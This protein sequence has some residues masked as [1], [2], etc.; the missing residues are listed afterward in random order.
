MFC[1]Q[2]GAAS[3]GTAAACLQCGVDLT[4]RV[5]PALN[6]E[7]AVAASKDA[8][9]ALKMLLMDPVGSVGTAYEAL[10]GRQATDVGIA[11]CAFFVISCVIAIRMIARVA[12]RLSFGA[13]IFSI[14]LKEA[15]QIALVAMVPVV[16][17]I[18]IFVGM[19]LIAT[20]QR[21]W[22]RAIFSGGAVLLPVALFNVVGGL[23]GVAN[24][25]VLALVA[26]FALCYTILLIYAVCHDVLKVSSA[27]S[28]AAVPVIMLAT[29]W[30]A[31]IILAAVM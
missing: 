22:A 30:L 8:A 1:S 2:C 12:Q 19:Q 20:K 6:T 14:G 21:D 13:S 7:R 10:V 27:A 24:A 4:P 29:A 11:F 18:A 15:L 17:I 16:S 28:A 9:R 3:D 31:K 5:R 25:E 26:L 23:L